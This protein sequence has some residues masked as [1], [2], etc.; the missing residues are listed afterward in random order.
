VAL[1][2]CAASIIKTRRGS[3]SFHKI[4]W[5]STDELCVANGDLLLPRL[6]VVAALDR[7]LARAHNRPDKPQEKREPCS[8]CAIGRVSLLYTIDR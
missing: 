3:T 7:L 5:T 2:D 8:V 1:P 6:A 4:K